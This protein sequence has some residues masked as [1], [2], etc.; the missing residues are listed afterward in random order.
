MKKNLLIIFLVC[1]MHL[2]SNAQPPQGPPPQQG[3]PPHKN[4]QAIKVAFITRQLNLTAEEAQKFWPVYNAYSESIK[5]IRIEQK[6]DVLGFEEKALAERKKL[7]A[8]MKKIL[9]SEDRANIAMKI[10]RDFNEVLRNELK[11]RRDNG[12]GNG[13]KRKNSPPPN[14]PNN[15]NQ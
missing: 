15:N 4:I 2:V 5:K 9:V 1:L 7:K 3:P 13:K 6:Q 11:E 14:P 10:D 8:E 12:N